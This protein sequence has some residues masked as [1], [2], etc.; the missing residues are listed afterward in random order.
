MNFEKWYDNGNGIYSQ[1]PY[2]S[3]SDN[4]EE[5]CARYGWDACKKEVLKVLKSCDELYRDRDGSDDYR[6]GPLVFKEIEKL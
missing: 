4:I 6:V 1:D 2:L 5:E 3:D